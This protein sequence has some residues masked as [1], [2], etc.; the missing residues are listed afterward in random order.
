MVTFEDLA[1]PP[2]S[3]WNGSDG[4]GKFT[5]SGAEFRNTYTT[6]Y[7]SWSGFAYSSTT[8][9]TTAGYGNQY[10]AY[11]GHGAGGSST[12]AVSYG[13]SVVKFSSALSLVGK[14]ASITNT[15]YAALVILNGD[16][17]FGTEAFTPGDWFK[18]TITGYQASLPTGAVEFYL[19]DYRAGS[20]LV[21][22]WQQV[23]FSSLGTV[24]ELRFGLSSSDNSVFGGFS[25]MNTPGYFA[26]DNL[27]AVP[28]PGSLLLIASGG[29][30]LL[31]R[32]RR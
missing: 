12:Y 16:S 5:S 7:G 21:N 4:S 6:A 10:S 20:M 25:Y 2:N 14:G 32:R 22:D 30:G 29:L 8:D 17:A 15:T 9:K 28:E 26:L 11:P 27:L 23:D 13:D 3:Y 1:S 31:T 19:A 18:L 24:D